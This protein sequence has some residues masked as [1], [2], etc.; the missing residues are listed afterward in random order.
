MRC[1]YRRGYTCIATVYVHVFANFT[2]SETSFVQVNIYI[3]SIIFFFN[4][5]SFF[6]HCELCIKSFIC[7]NR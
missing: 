5:V 1:L 3:K 6:R 2:V 7:C 4:L